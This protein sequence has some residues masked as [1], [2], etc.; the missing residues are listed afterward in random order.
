MRR[1]RFKLKPK[2]D[3]QY[4]T[5]LVTDIRGFSEMAKHINTDLLREFIDEFIYT[6]YYTLKEFSDQEEE[7]IDLNCFL[8]DGWLIF[9]K[10][11]LTAIQVALTLRRKFNELRKRNEDPEIQK[12]GIGTAIH[13]G[14]EI[15][16]GPFGTD[17]ITGV[18]YDVNL[19][20]RLSDYATKGEILVTHNVYIEIRKKVIS[21][22]KDP[23]ELRGIH[24]LQTPW[25]VLR[26]TKT[27]EDETCCNFC[28]E[29]PYC[30][31][32]YDL[33][34]NSRTIVEGS[35]Q[36]VKSA[37]ILLCADRK[38]E[39]PIKKR[40]FPDAN[41]I[42]CG[43]CEYVEG[44]LKNIG[45]AKIEVESN[46]TIIKERECC[47][48]CDRFYQCSFNWHIGKNNTRRY[49]CEICEF[50]SSEDI[51]PIRDFINSNEISKSMRKGDLVNKLGQPIS[52]DENTLVYPITYKRESVAKIEFSIEDNLIKSWTRCS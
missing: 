46:K 19:A 35:N 10:E 15:I 26:E 44:C 3:K 13:R 30:T 25:S 41:L 47:Y 31:W 8:G 34:F 16:F 9:F 6:T 4:L 22:L 24:D 50:F 14:N 11:P 37:N 5:V 7:N 18:G 12:L 40:E 23:L 38:A 2:A 51:C 1:F 17:I 43:C 33:A 39:G 36:G 21:I 42:F 27:N 20:F 28:Y 48:Y 29:Y 52:S 32:S 45:R 49:C